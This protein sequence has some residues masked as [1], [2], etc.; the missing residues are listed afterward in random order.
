[1]NI[2]VYCY[3]DGVEYDPF[4]EYDFGEEEW[5]VYG[6]G[7][8]DS[9]VSRHA[10]VH[11]DSF[12]VGYTGYESTEYF[13]DLFNSSGFT[14]WDEYNPGSPVV[15]TEHD[16]IAECDFTGGL[17]GGVSLTK[18]FTFSFADTYIT[19][20][21]KCFAPT[22]VETV[23]SPVVAG[24]ACGATVL[25]ANFYSDGVL[26]RLNGHELLDGNTSTTEFLVADMDD[27]DFHTV[28]WRI[29]LSDLPESPTPATPNVFLTPQVLS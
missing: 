26:F 25:F 1:M 22:S 18:S 20:H 11:M 3:V 6:P 28:G 19:T 12:V 15:L 14:M 21:T 8:S 5:D 9:D 13:E 24:S 4:V 17:L 23:A 27:G 16:G 10:E 29:H 2:K 7:A